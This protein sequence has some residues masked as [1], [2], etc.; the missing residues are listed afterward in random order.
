MKLAS[1]ASSSLTVGHAAWAAATVEVHAARTASGTGA[2]RPLARV[3]SAIT[4]IESYRRTASWHN[5]AAGWSVST[6][7]QS[8]T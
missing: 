1:C 5:A 4:S 7:M 2:G 6:P 8:R 3:S